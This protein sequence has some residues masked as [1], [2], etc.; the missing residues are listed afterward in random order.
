MRT[1]KDETSVG[2]RRRF[3]SSGNSP[4]GLLPSSWSVRREQ[5]GRI[6]DRGAGGE[7]ASGLGGL[8]DERFARLSIAV[9]SFGQRDPIESAQNHLRAVSDEA[10]FYAG[11]AFGVTLAP[12][13]RFIARWTNSASRES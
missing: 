7:A 2:P 8:L 5:R 9:E 4:G 3:E 1:R 10:Y 13:A 6:N 11:L 12:A